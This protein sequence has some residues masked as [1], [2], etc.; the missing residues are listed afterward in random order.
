MTSN[1]PINNKIRDICHALDNKVWYFVS[2]ILTVFEILLRLMLAN[3]EF[4]L[5]YK[6]TIN[7]KERLIQF[8]SKFLRK[9][10]YEYE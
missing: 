3:N 8:A 7:D 6:L 2:D 10:D 9:W 5:S 1:N 4:T